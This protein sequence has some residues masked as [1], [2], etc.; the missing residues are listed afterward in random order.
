MTKNALIVFT[1]NPELGQCKTRLAKTIGNQAALDIYKYLLAHTANV[2]EAIDADRFVFY[3]EAIAN[4]D[5]WPNAY[6]IKKV[7]IGKD[8]GE[9]MH[10]A[11]ANLFELG[12]SKVVIIGSDLLDLTPVIIKK[13]FQS[14]D[15]NNV[16]L[17][18]AEDG[19]YYLLG[20]KE[21]H[22]NIFQN[23]SWGTETVRAETLEDLKNIKVSLLRELNDIDTFDDMKHYEQLKRFYKTHD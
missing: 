12:Y 18:P 10:N 22:F 1:R 6:F 15:T 20:M 8:L 7:Q 3:S 14:L 13:A 5:L 11:F 19:G 4:K 21:L 9:R 16:V 23:K 2:A 17:G